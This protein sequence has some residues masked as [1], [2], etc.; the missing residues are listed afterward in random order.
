M[1]E[2]SGV[3]IFDARMAGKPLMGGE[4]PGRTRK[5]RERFEWRMSQARDARDMLSAATDYVR[6]TFADYPLDQAAEVCDRLV[7]LA[8][9]ERRR[10]RGGA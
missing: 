6:A 5:R 3:E 2:M 10:I 7:E 1:A 9:Q 4:P 8:D